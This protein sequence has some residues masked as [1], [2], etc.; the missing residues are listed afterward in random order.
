ML[1]LLRTTLVVGTAL[2]STTAALAADGGFLPAGVSGTL[3]VTT[4]YVDAG[5]SQTLGHFAVQ[6]GLAWT[7]ES[8][9]RA[10]FFA[11][12]MD[13]GIDD[14]IVAE[15]DPYVGYSNSFT[16]LGG[17]FDYALSATYNFHP[18]HKIDRAAP[19]N[20][21]AREKAA[22]FEDLPEASIPIN[23]DTV[24][25]D[26]DFLE[27]GAEL[28]REISLGTWS[29]STAFSPD[30]PGGPGSVVALAAGLSYPVTDELSVDV[31]VQ[32]T[33]TPAAIGADYIDWNAGL[34]YALEWVGLDLRYHK[35]QD[36]ACDGGC[37][38]RF[39]FSV[40]REF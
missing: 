31:N 6:G 10:G 11:S 19:A 28:S 14:P 29:V 25:S 26:Y 37:R 5:L 7:H 21:I 34:S 32:R 38:S 16:A 15:F 27:L 2:L 18:R 33:W 4:D 3:V 13:F 17:N 39:T 23:P 20:A 36:R 30:G 22:A 40:T 12:N 24:N 8:G 1:S 35:A 9:A